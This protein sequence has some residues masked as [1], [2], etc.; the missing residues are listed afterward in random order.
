MNKGIIWTLR[1]CAVDVL[2]GWALDLAPAEMKGP[3]AIAIRNLILS[4]REFVRWAKENG[5]L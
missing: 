4:D 5:H 3:L 2:L 1:M